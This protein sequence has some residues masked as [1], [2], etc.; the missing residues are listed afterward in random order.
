[1]R[2]V[3]LGRE[4]KGGHMLEERAITEQNHLGRFLQFPDV[5]IRKFQEND[6]NLDKK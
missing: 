3:C 2:Q 6:V 5:S 1:M 4:E